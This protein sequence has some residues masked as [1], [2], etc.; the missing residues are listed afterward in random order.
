MRDYYR[1]KRKDLGLKSGTYFRDELV[2]HFSER[3]WVI[4]YNN[5]LFEFWNKLLYRGGRA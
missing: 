2:G 3:Q 5:I 4:K 1:N